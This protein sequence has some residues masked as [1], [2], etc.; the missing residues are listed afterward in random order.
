MNY[1]ILAAELALPAYTG[2]SDQ[3]AADSLN[4]ANIAVD[5]ETVGGVDIFEATTQTDYAAL[6]ATQKNL[7][8]AIIGMENIKVKGSN[9]R[10]A[11]LAMFGAGTQTRTN[12][13]ALQT[14]QTSRAEQL[15][16]PHV[17]A[18]HVAYARANGG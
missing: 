13:A 11:L 16:L 7:Y 3:A 14:T 10:A 12:M 1:Q 4:N 8:H 6:T 9:T 2:L 15:G 18:H 17:G 5:V